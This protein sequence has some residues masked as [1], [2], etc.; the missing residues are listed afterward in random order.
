MPRNTVSLV[1]YQDKR[2]I[3]RAVEECGGLD[4]L[5]V[6]ASVLIK[7]NL[8]GWDDQGP[9]PPW[10]VLT[11]S[12]VIE[13]LC[14]MLRDAGAKRICLG[15]GS[16]QCRSI[17][18]DTKIIYE[19]LGY[20]KLTERYGVELLDFNDGPFLD[21]P[22]PGDSLLK[23]AA[24]VFESD[25]LINVPVLKTHG[26]T[27]ISLG[28]KNLKGV[29]QGRTKIQCH[30]PEGLLDRFIAFLAE[31]ISPA[32]TLIDGIYANE[33]GPLHFGRAHRLNLLSASTDIY[34]ADLLGAHLLGYGCDEV[35]HLRLLAE[36]TGRVKTVEDLDIR[37]DLDLA[38]VRRPL[39]WDWEWSPDG[40]VPVA[41]VKAGLAGVTLRH[42]DATLCTGCSYLFN[43]L[44]L[45]LLS[46]KE[47]DLGGV[48]FLTGK[49]MKPTGGVKK[50]FL[51]GACQITAAAKN[52][53]LM[54][55]VP[56]RGCPPTIAEILQV[57]NDNGINVD[58]QTYDNYRQHIMRRYASAPDIYPAAHFFL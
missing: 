17:G 23:V 48:E 3:D 27:K 33:Q 36:K 6:G 50:T 1:R 39:R 58:R 38:A 16:I 14:R 30:Q 28:M 13:G 10:G 29:L 37:T 4:A 8:V 9:Y 5:P 40:A 19:K 26:T 18:S 54:D 45:I 7:P 55:A 51:F 31:K 42:Y 57:L 49:I 56:I 32:L 22:G 52:P 24:P 46:A 43:P 53:E 47:K 2:S 21:L 35:E 12:E 25:F 41:F 11:T 15:E 20:V 34:A 44:M